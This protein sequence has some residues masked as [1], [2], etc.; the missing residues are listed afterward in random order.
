V[1][2][3][4]AS[5]QV[6]WRTASTAAVALVLLVAA[7]DNDGADEGRAGPATTAPARTTTEASRT[8][9]IEVTT[10]SVVEVTTTA[11]PHGDPS[12]GC[13]S[14][15]VTPTPGTPL[16]AEPLDIIRGQM[17]VSGEFHVVEM[18]YFTGPEVPW[19]INPRPVLVQRWY[20]KAWL[21]DEPTF[22]ARWLVERRS[23]AVAGI[24]GVAPFDTT[25]YQSPDWRG[26]IGESD[27][28]YAIEGLPGTWVGF[29]Y[30]FIT[31]ETG[32]NRGLPDEIEHCLDGT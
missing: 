12:P 30:D 22:R 13:Y 8:S 29:N 6:T 5:S 26:F 2:G 25:G 18:R 31:G 32:D 27:E 14:G 11:P 4:N 24:G 23:E 20:V 7:C 10:T 15:W 21:V 9:T 19:I 16:R 1:L 3:L 28:P 17:G